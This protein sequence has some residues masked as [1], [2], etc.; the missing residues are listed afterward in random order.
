MSKR[1]HTCSTY[2]VEYG[3]TAAFNYGNEYF[4]YL[5]DA[6]TESEDES[7]YDYVRNEFDDD[8]ELPVE[9]YVK[10]LAKLKKLT[11]GKCDKRLADIICELEASCRYISC[12]E[13]ELDEYIKSLA[14]WCEALYAQADTSDGYIHF[15]WF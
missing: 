9:L 13:E 4:I 12:T 1:L 8:F 6:L 10:F 3:G 5:I 7:P 14:E 11:A 2:K 15:A